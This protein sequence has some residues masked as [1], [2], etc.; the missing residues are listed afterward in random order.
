MSTLLL[1]IF[2]A[3]TVDAQMFGFASVVME[4]QKEIRQPL[5]DLEDKLQSEVSNYHLFVFSSANNPKKMPVS[6]LNGLS[7]V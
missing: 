1:T 7:A 3:V 4:Q 2:R 5:A 6:Q